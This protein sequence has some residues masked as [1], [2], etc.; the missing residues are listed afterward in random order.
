L[1]VIL[2]GASRKASA[3]EGPGGQQKEGPH[4]IH[5]SGTC[6]GKG[7]LRKVILIVSNRVVA[8]AIPLPQSNNGG[9]GAP[10]P[11]E[12]TLAAQPP[13]FPM[14]QFASGEEGFPK[15]ARSARSTIG[16]QFSAITSFQPRKRTAAWS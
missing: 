12:K 3:V 16:S 13:L 11:F 6:D 14:D 8:A 7:A 2:S 1:R 4:V 5:L 9:T 10:S 15:R